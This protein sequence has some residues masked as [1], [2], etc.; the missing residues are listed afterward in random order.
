METDRTGSRPPP[1]Q[2]RFDLLSGRGASWEATYE[3]VVRGTDAAVS[4]NGVRTIAYR[5]A[6][7]MPTAKLGIQLRVTTAVAIKSIHIKELPDN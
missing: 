3:I 6:Q 2:R 1:P 7:A 5:H 4:V